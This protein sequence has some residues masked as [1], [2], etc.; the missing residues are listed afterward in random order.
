M[1]CRSLVPGGRRAVAARALATA[2]LIGLSSI[3]G[4]SG[5]GSSSLA[6]GADPPPRLLVESTATLE[7]TDLESRFTAVAN[8]V[9]PSVVAISAAV[10][11]VDSDDALRSTTLNGQKLDSV[12]QHITRT[13]GTGFVIDADGYILTNEHVIADASQVWITTDDR[14]VY[15]AIVIGS[16][17]RADL[18][19]LK[20]PVH[21]MVPVRFADAPSVHRGMWTIAL[22][23]PYG[24]ASAGEMSMSVGVV[25]AVDRS[26]C[27]SSRHRRTVSTRT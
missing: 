23:N 8:Q 20:A 22:G 26:R 6:A 14:K 4:L 24:L 2:G 5:I 13:V 19:V 7:L 27:Q 3:V 12:L 10:G 21:G 1:G 15:P 17:P 9:A 18:A 25:S 16:D 11:A